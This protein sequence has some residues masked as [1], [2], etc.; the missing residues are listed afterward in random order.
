MFKE[1]GNTLTKQPKAASQSVSLNICR[2][3]FVEYTIYRSKSASSNDTRG[4]KYLAPI[5]EASTHCQNVADIGENGVV[6]PPGH[7]GRLGVPG[8]QQW[9]HF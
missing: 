7:L 9:R 2:D 8:D 4:E 6:L 5:P 3:L 1:F